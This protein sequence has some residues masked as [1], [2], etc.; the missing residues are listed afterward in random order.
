MAAAP[1]SPT[2]YAFPDQ[3]ELSRRA[4]AAIVRTILAAIQ[5]R[6]V[7]AVALAGGK[8]P[9][10]VYQ[11]IVHEHSARIPWA[12][13]HLFWG[14]ERY[15]PHDDPRSNYRM[16]QETLIDHVPIPAVNVHPMPTDHPSP[17]NAAAAYEDLLT[18]HFS[19]R[20]PRIDLILLGLAADGHCASLFPGS[21]ALEVTDRLVVATRVAAEPPRRLTLTFPAINNAA[22]IYFLVIGSAKAEA[23]R[24]AVD[25]ES[26]P[27]STP[28]AGVRPV[29]GHLAWWVD[30]A[31]ASR[32]DPK[33]LEASRP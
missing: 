1:T 23:L 22:V 19:D 17:D 32:L 20:R 14:D 2:V 26:D 28:A 27:K 8:T 31:A 16:A 7:C 29:D 30:A 3:E 33:L 18:R 4:A 5:R 9:G 12:Q 10:P 11:R 25:S 15:V 13:L 21:P 24:H 6:G